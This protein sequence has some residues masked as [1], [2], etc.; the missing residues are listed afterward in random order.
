MSHPAYLTHLQTTYQLPSFRIYQESIIH[1]IIT[2]PSVAA[3]LPTGMG[4]TLLYQ[5][6]TTFLKLKTVV[7]SPLIALIQDQ[8]RRAVELNIP[9]WQLHSLQSKADNDRFYQSFITE[10]YG[11]LLISPERWNSS[12]RQ[13]IESS[14]QSILLVIDEAHCISTWG[15]S[16][17]PDYRKMEYRLADFPNSKLLVLSA[18]PTPDLIPSVK[19]QFSIEHISV[20]TGDLFR[21]N[22]SYVAVETSS[23]TEFLSHALRS[24]SEPCIIYVQSRRKVESIAEWLKEIGIN[25]GKYHAGL[26]MNVKREEATKFLS[27]ESQVMVAT[28]AFGMGIDKSNIRF[29]F[30][31]DP[32]ILTSDYLQESGRA[33]RDGK[34]S[35]AYL[36]LEHAQLEVMKQTLRLLSQL[37]FEMKETKGFFHAPVR[38]NDIKVQRF[39]LLISSL[40]LKHIR[41]WFKELPETQWISG[42]QTEIMLHLSRVPESE[43][44]S[45]MID[46]LIHAYSGMIQLKFQQVDLIHLEKVSG[47]AKSEWRKFIQ[48]GVVEGFIEGKDSEVRDVLPNELNW[49]NDAPNHVIISELNKKKEEIEFWLDY[50]SSKHCLMNALVN[51]LGVGSSTHLC[52]LCSYCR[53]LKHP[54]ITTHDYFGLIHYIEEKKVVSYEELLKEKSNWWA[55]DQKL[56]VKHIQQILKQGLKENKVFEVRDS[57]GSYFTSETNPVPFD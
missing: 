11:I 34:S 24:I 7:I 43:H 45:A 33:G 1:E 48:K 20:F 40:Y 37:I 9:V 17:R 53:S 27:G 54:V 52:G 8:Y 47:Q 29:I 26:E 15:E 57:E 46:Y 16:F 21:H 19:K 5:F 49:K 42:D 12:I 14:G 36:I 31:I 30:H 44:E 41:E 22:L 28:N 38:L 3:F 4:K 6:P 18:T 56:P 23:H 39:R 10:D 35:F 2:Q 32:P 25:S 55:G 51:R 13:K 50:H